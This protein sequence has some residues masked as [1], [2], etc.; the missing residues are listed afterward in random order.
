[1][2]WRQYFLYTFCSLLI[3][4]MIAIAQGF[5]QGDVFLRQQQLLMSLVLIISCGTIFFL[6]LYQ[7]IH[8]EYSRQ[9]RSEIEQLIWMRNIQ[10][11]QIEQMMLADNAIREVK[12][13]IK[14]HVLVIETLAEEEQYDDLK[15]YCKH[16]V[17]DS[18]KKM[19][20]MYCDV[21]PINAILNNMILQAEK[22][23]V[24]VILD[25]HSTPLVEMDPFDACIVIS[26]VIKNAIEASERG[27][28][29]QLITHKFQERDYMLCENRI[30]KP[31]LME[32]GK[33]VTDKND[34]KTHGFGLRN[35]E[36]TVR[37]YGGKVLYQSRSDTFRVEI[38]I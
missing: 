6:C 36:N 2:D 38:V 17:A 37:K 14:Q 33:I 3:F 1:L 16:L 10:D 9:Q 21:P 27:D 24:E 5:G 28:V 15:K 20:K 26:N 7:N 34:K 22:K 29:I 19:D 8:Y 31:I 11:A 25:F 32:G 13:D 30:H 18:L 4:V 35:I 12:H 23:N